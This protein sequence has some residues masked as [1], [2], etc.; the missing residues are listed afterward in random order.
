LSSGLLTQVKYARDLEPSVLDA[1]Y[2]RPQAQL[3]VELGRRMSL[4][5][6]AEYCRI[7]A[8]RCM[9]RAVELE[10]QSPDSA[11]SQSADRG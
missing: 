10:A 1:H 5:G 3:Y 2:F 9:A 11:S 6:D 7:T 4:R 8:E